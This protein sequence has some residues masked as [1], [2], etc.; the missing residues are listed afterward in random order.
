MHLDFC[1]IEKK[2]NLFSFRNM[3]ARSYITY[4]ILRENGAHDGANI[5]CSF[6]MSIMA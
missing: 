4:I 5:L 6:R 1:H 3:I 2:D